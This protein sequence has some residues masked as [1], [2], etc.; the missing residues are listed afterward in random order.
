LTA[1]KFFIQPAQEPLAFKLGG[2][3]MTV[4]LQV[5]ESAIVAVLSVVF[6]FY[7]GVR[8]GVMRHKHNIL[9]PATTG[10]P[11]FECAYRVQMN[12][13]ENFALFLPL[14]WIAAFL[15]H[16]V[17]YLV[18]A[19]GILWVIGRILYMSGYMKSPEKRGLGGRIT[20]LAALILLVLSI[21]GIVQAWSAATAAQQ[22]IWRFAS[23]PLFPYSTPKHAQRGGMYRRQQNR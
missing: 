20:A 3:G 8:T 18:P 19:V 15:F 6:V 4:T 22:R 13:L 17:A 23:E 16:S 21:I 11:E 7:T 12:T 10:H 1:V 14:F 5:L 2:I 9:P